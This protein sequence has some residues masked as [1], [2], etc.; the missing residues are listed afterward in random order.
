MKSTG[1]N[2]LLLNLLLLTMIGMLGFTKPGYLITG[3]V[4]A[5]DG[6]VFKLFYRYGDKVIAD[7]VA[8]KNNTFSL[9]GTF[10]E[11]VVCTLSNSANQQIK[12]FVA[13][14]STIKVEGKVEQFV[15]ASITNSSE[16]ALYNHFNSSAHAISGRYR[17]MLKQSGAAIRDTG[18]TA[19]KVYK[20]SHDSLVQSFVKQHSSST[21]AALAI[22][23]SYVTNPDR[24]R[25][26]ACYS[27]LSAKGK[28]TIYAR[29]IKQFFEAEKVIA[30]GHK[31]PDFTLTD[32]NGKPVKLSDYKGKYILLDF[33]ASWCAP[34]RHE[35]PL[36]IELYKKFGADKLTFLSVSMDAG[37][38][39]WKQAVKTDGLVWTQLNDAQSMNGRVADVYGIKS[40]PF[41]CIIDPNGQIIATKLR[42]EQL[43]GF[44]TKLFDK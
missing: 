4:S 33:W 3:S 38:A 15:N 23:D 21:A 40:L 34:C 22:T 20:A 10:P 31:A 28:E 27:L 12:I 6:T 30:P 19:Y 42:G 8:T 44:I 5:P 39:Q 26:A 24:V 29:R 2:I 7:S 36:M 1:K 16:N 35:H 41:N 17:A 11:P 37:S 32:I 43:S 9:S 25:A 18:T 13:E 14:N